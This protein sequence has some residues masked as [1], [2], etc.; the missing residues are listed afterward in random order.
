MFQESN[1]SLYSNSLWGTFLWGYSATKKSIVPLR[2]RD[3][4]PSPSKLTPL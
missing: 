2:T 1:P 3:A 4:S